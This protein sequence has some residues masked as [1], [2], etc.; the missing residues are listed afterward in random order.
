MLV[1]VFADS[2]TDTADERASGRDAALASGAHFL[3]SDFP[4]DTSA[5]E[6]FRIPE[7]APVGC[8]PVTAPAECTAVALEDPTFVR[9]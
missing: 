6:A 5:G 1:R 3:S 7:G 8:N 9:H 4:V 2:A